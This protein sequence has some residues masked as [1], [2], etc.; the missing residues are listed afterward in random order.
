MTRVVA[1]AAL[2]FSL[3]HQLSP[4]P[5]SGQVSA[6]GA[7][8]VFLGPNGTLWVWGS[9]DP[10]P[11]PTVPS[12]IPGILSLATGRSYT[13]I[14]ASDG[15]VWIWG[16]QGENQDRSSATG[17]LPTGLKGAAAISAA[18]DHTLA[19]KIDGSVWRWTPG[20]P[21]AS[22]AGLPPVISISAGAERDLA[23]AFDGTV[24]AWSAHA[25]PKKMAGFSGVVAIATGEREVAALRSDGT[26]WIRAAEDDTSGGAEPRMVEGLTGVI[27]VAAGA[28]HAL[29]LLRNGKVV[30]WGSNRH[31]QLGDGSHE[32]RAHRADVR[33]LEDVV[34]IAAGDRHS[35]A[36]K[37]DGSLW[38]WG[39]NTAGQLAK[40]KTV[41]RSNVPV[42]IPFR[43]ATATPTFDHDDVEPYDEPFEVVITCDTP[44]ATIRYTTDDSE[45]NLSSPVYTTAIPITQNTPLRAKAWA[46]TV[47]IASATAFADYRLKVTAPTPSP[48]PGTHVVVQSVSV[49]LVTPTEGATIHYT[50]GVD[51]P[52]PTCSSPEYTDAILV[53]QSTTIRAIGCKDNWDD[54]AEAGGL[55][56]LKVAP[57]TFLPA[58][59]PEPQTHWQELDVSLATTTDGDT[60]HYTAGL[61]PPDPTCSSPEY[62]GEILVNQTTTIKAIGCKTGWT[63]SDMAAATYT[64][65]V[66]TPQLS[67]PEG[68]YLEAKDVEVTTASPDAI[69]HYSTNG[70]EPTETDPVVESGGMVHVDRSMTLKVKGWRAGWQTSA[71]AR[72]S[73]WINLGT[74]ATP[75]LTP[76]PG[77]QPSAVSVE[78]DSVTPG[79]TIRYTTDGTEP[80]FSSPVY[81]GP[82]P[83]ASTTDLRA[84]AFKADMTPSAAGGL[85]VIDLGTVDPPRFSPG[86][87]TYPAAQDVVISSET[88]EATIHYTTNGLDPLE[89]DPAVTEPIRVD[90]DMVLKAK[91]WKAGMPAS[92]VTWAR[93][94]FT[95]AVAVGSSHSLAL[96]SDGT[97]WSWGSNTYGK[98]GEPGRPET[99][100]RWVPGMVQDLTDVIAIAAGANHSLALKR[101]GTVWAW[102][103]NG[104]GQL[105]NSGGNTAQATQVAGLQDVV[106]VGISAGDGHSLVLTDEGKVMAFGADGVTNYEWTPDT[107]AGLFGITKLA[108]GAAQSYA[109]KTDGTP[110]GAL[111]AWGANLVGQLGDDTTASRAAAALVANSSDRT[112]IAGGYNHGMALKSDGTVWGWGS[113]TQG[114]LGDGTAERRLAPVPALGLGGVAAIAAGK[115]FGL[116]L[117]PDSSVWAWGWNAFG[118]LA[119]GNTISS[120]VPIQSIVFSGTTAIAAHNSAVH[121][122]ALRTDGTLRA[123]GNN[124]NGQLGDNTTAQREFPVTVPNFSLKQSDLIS[125][126]TDGDGLSN[127]AEVAAGT[128]PLNPDTNGD[129]IRDGAAIASGQSP[130]DLD[131]DDDGVSNA[132]EL[133]RGTD[134]FMNDTDG[135]GVYDGPDCFPLDPTRAQCPPNDP[136]DITPPLITL[137]EP[138]NATLI[139]VVPPP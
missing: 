77:P 46:G 92:P 139:S 90:E 57:P 26:V 120:P 82:I 119:T 124:F 91:A 7:Q 28:E 76:A 68:S 48:A 94:E 6:G 97:V 110:T 32:D 30:S 12:G 108:A 10:Q 64:F 70:A 22:V 96:K 73:Y 49:S 75:I 132:D 19:W 128:D 27:A 63:I 101:N 8:S 5:R 86:G 38:G 9:G 102:G 87:G 47:N 3:F 11:A 44:N 69:L 104:V 39:D 20:E 66:A 89:S 74:V 37:S 105:G 112:A 24:W 16:G 18:G 45:P 29:A 14:L 116:A 13:A 138:T 103:Y 34:A 67:V 109:L 43:I 25:P 107:I 62:T 118:N 134:P 78:I 79:A 35:L 59:L 131:M 23:V 126:D 85:Y 135:D 53:T 42:R 122:L 72:A 51:P 83:V 137:E 95:G 100:D 81:L 21:P 31:G 129:G 99:S 130:T 1:V 55:Y 133:A 84:K 15:T 111:W 17:L 98:L 71:T 61:N 58:P 50:A 88:S 40:P 80:G 41:A 113:N 117:K 60:I 36:L 123:W 54:S 65:K 56:K 121:V 2:G 52:L 125:L 127:A 136:N 106:V 115:A 4:S 93:Y 114:E 33:D